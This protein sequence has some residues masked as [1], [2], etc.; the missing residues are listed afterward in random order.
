MTEGTG[1]AQDQG[2]RHRAKG[3][4]SPATAQLLA[5]Y[6]AAMRD[7]LAGILDELAPKAPA[8]GLGLVDM[9][10]TRPPL[11]E[12]A[13]LWSLAMQLGRELGTAIDPGPDP[14]A[15]PPAPPARRRS[16]RIDFG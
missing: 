5:R 1:R 4:P 13:R 15:P 8:P 2:R 16:S 10:P 11:A 12:R 3:R 6:Q 7:E 9:A 14:D